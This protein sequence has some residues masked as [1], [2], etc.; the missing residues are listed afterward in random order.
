VT[1]AGP[2]VLTSR[3]TRRRAAWDLALSAV[4]LVVAYAAY[5]IAFVFAFLQL[6]LL[7]PCATAG[8]GTAAA[9]NIQFLA[10]LGVFLVGVL[11][12]A[13]VVVLQ[14][15]RRR[16]WW[17]ATATLVLTLGGWILASVLFQATLLR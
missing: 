10:A 8:C 1:G 7:T 12:T 14:V 16:S 17:A 9:G 2:R 11:G 13:G 6:S 5:W 3:T 4:L 15:L